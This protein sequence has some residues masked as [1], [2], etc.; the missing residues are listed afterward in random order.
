MSY[1][2][3]VEKLLDFR[4]LNL[5]TANSNLPCVEA[6][7]TA[8]EDGTADNVD[9]SVDLLEV[10]EKEPQPKTGSA[11]AGEHGDEEC[12]NNKD[13]FSRKSSVE[14]SAVENTS[15]VIANES[16]NAAEK[17]DSRAETPA[18]QVPSADNPQQSIELASVLKEGQ[19]AEEFFRETA[20]QLT[21]YGLS[22]LHQEV[23]YSTWNEE[24]DSVLYRS[25]FW[26]LALASRLLGDCDTMFSL[27][28]VTNRF[29]TVSCPSSSATITSRLCSSLRVNCTSL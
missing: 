10:S 12:R 27:L 25:F 19:A 18:I 2:K 24:V 6:D 13:D 20:S 29:G 14:G 5:K 21:Y 9:S 3:L 8:N 26:S 11:P 23:Q 7:T 4:S 22:R 1:N 15:E 16:G 28:N 17:S